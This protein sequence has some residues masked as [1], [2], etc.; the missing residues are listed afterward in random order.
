MNI[1]SIDKFILS[2]L[3]EN[4]RITN[5][6][7]SKRIKLSPS[8]TLERVKKLESNDSEALD[9]IKR[10]FFISRTYQKIYLLNYQSKK[11]T[12]V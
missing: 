12:N 3:Q 6:E 1:D 8:S 7:L 4:A 9:G 10:Q 5:S 2:E 11:L